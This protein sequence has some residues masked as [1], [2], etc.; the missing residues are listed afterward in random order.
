MKLWAIDQFVIIVINAFVPVLIGLFVSFLLEPAIAYLE[1]KTIKRMMACLIV[2]GACVCVLGLIAYIL[3]PPLVL[4]F[5]EIQI[6]VPHFLE[7]Y[8]I[9]VYGII[10]HCIDYLGSL[11]NLGLGVGVAFFVSL[12]FKKVSRFYYD[13][14]PTNHKRKYREISKELGQ[15]IFMY[16]RY[17]L[18]DTMIL[19]FLSSLLLFVFQIQYP[20]AFGLGIALSNLIPYVGPLLGGIPLVLYGISQGVVVVCLGIVIGIQ[21]IENMFISP[22]LLNNMISLHPL[23]GVLALSLFGS[24]LGFWGVVFSRLIMALLKILYRHWFLL[25]KKGKMVYNSSEIDDKDK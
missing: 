9:N 10:N 24:L 1:R 5:K 11:S 14:A 4:Q 16:C 20:L 2:Y 7:K 15:T 17:L 25:E 19:F 22:Y 3:I 23:L 8:E 6:D 18:Y 21:F 12:D 13:L